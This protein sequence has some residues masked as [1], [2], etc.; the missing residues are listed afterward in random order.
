MDGL[1]LL[2]LFAGETEWREGVL[3]E[4]WPGRGVFS[5]VH[6]GKY[7]Y[8]E[9]YEDSD[10]FYDLTA[11]PYQLENKINDP[12]FQELIEKHRQLLKYL[13]SSP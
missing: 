7:V 6:S 13:Q 8:A 9:I 12:A 11:D 1:S 3:L 2:D 10:E 4:G 5:A